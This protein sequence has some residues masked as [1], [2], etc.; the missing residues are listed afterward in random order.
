MQE[1][2]NELCIIYPLIYGSELWVCAN[3]F[4]SLRKQTTSCQYKLLKKTSAAHYR[5]TIGLVVLESKHR[6]I[7]YRYSFGCVCFNSYAS[8]VVPIFFSA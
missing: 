5:G 7:K 1:E 2:G 6:R 8:E 3:Y 4:Y